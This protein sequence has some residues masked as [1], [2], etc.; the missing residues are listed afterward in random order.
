MRIKKLYKKA[1][2]SILAFLIVFQTIAGIFLPVEIS[3]TPPYV[4]LQETQAAGESWMTGWSYRRAITITNAQTDFQIKVEIQGSNA[5]NPN[6]VDFGKILAGGADVRFTD[7]GGSNALYYWIESWD[8]T[9][10]SEAATIWVRTDAT[11]ATPMYMYYGKAG[12]TTTSNG[13]N[14]F[15]FFDDIDNITGWTGDG[16]EDTSDYHTSPASL[17]VHASIDCEGGPCDFPDTKTAT[18]AITLSS[19]NKKVEYYGKKV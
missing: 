4:S 3:L 8:D 6:Y 19:G 9:G 14:T 13:T 18:K 2:S 11:A 10:G 16:T 15:E 17:K 7:S 1:T 12:E 5:S